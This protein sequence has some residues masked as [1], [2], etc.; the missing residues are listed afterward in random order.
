MAEQ[1]YSY[2]DAST[3]C[4]A[5]HSSRLLETSA[6]SLWKS[7]LLDCHHGAGYG[8]TFETHPTDDLT[9]VVAIAGRH[10]LDAFHSGRWRSVLYQPGSAGMTPPGESLRLRWQTPS[11][12]EWFRTLH[13]YLPGSLLSDIADEYRRVGQP[14]DIKKLSALA[15]RDEAVAVQLKAILAAYRNGEPDLYAAGVSRAIA[16]HL[17]S[18]QAQ[19]RHVAEDHRVS[20]TITDRRL[21]RAIEFMSEHLDRALTLEELAREAGI[22]VHHFGKRFR[23]STGL[24]PS[25][26]LTTL[27]IAR[28]RILLRT[29]ELSVAQVAFRCGYTHPAAFAT[30]FTR[31]SG[32]SPRYYRAHGER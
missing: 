2:A 29:T 16:I 21:A 11:N 9:L 14:T 17:L 32:V 28:A 22:S 1:A 18:R 5:V 24:G 6:A 7:L 19:W 27:R 8:D 10:Q 26:Y 30:A 3:R 25:A 20:A 15:F 13:L 23:E 4:A 12:D 31:H